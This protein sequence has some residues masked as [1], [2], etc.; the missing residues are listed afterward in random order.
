MKPAESEVFTKQDLLSRITWTNNVRLALGAIFFVNFSLLVLLKIYVSP[1]YEAALFLGVY[2]FIYAFLTRYY[3][4]TQKQIGFFE[5]I[6]L[7]GFLVFIDLI[8]VTAFIY[9]TGAAESPW[10]V[11]YILNLASIPVMFP[12]FLSSIFVWSF[13]ASIFYDVILFMNLTGLRPFI[14]GF[15]PGSERAKEVLFRL[16]FINGIAIPSMLFFFATVAFYVSSYFIKERKRFEKVL[17]EEMGTQEEIASLTNITWILTRIFDLDYMLERVLEE[18]FKILRIHSGI[19]FTIAPKNEHYVKRISLGVPPQIANHLL[20]IEPGSLPSEDDPYLFKLLAE[21]K[22][23]MM[24]PKLIAA[25]RDI[26]IGMIVFFVREGEEVSKRGLFVLD[27]I[28]AEMGIALAYAIYIDK[29]K[30]WKRK[31]QKK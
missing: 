25:P 28:V 15:T 10:F 14:P 20:K 5:V 24:I 8:F 27:S 9:L 29:C 30:F 31:P 22:I 16:T 11:L 19:I 7:S 21:E 26:K 17:V 6:F 13:L 2:L 18:S 4:I 3:L 1:G 12:Y 23:K